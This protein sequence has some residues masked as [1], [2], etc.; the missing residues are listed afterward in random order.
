VRK[1]RPRPSRGPGKTR[2]V[3]PELARIR[4]LDFNDGI[5]QG[6]SF[7]DV[8]APATTNNAWQY[9]EA[10]VTL[11]AATPSIKVRAVRDGSNQGNAYFDGIMLQRSN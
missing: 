9:R 2:L 3:C 10:I 11:P 8:Q 4:R 7:T 6:A 1:G 5:A